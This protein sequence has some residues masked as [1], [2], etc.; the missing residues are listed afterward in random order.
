MCLSSDQIQRVLP[1]RYPFLLVD[2]IVEV[3]PTHCKAIKA[4][5][6]DAPFFQG[7]FPGQSIMPGNLIAE[8]MAQASAFVGVSIAGCQGGDVSPRMGWLVSMAIKW[9]GMV[10]PGDVLRITVEKK[11][12]LQD[13]IAYHGTVHVDDQLVCKGDFTVYHPPHQPAPHQPTTQSAEGGEA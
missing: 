4:V 9:S 8:S 7:H 6:V 1:H 5:S 11:K 12:A 10:I 2:R 3:S 13:M